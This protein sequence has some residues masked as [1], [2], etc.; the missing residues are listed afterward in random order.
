MFA[1]LLP[2]A[3]QVFIVNNRELDSVL[4]EKVRKRLLPV[5]LA[6]LP[7]IAVTPPT[8]IGRS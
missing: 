1:H 2:V 4:T 6:E 8:P 3:G 7:Q 5:K